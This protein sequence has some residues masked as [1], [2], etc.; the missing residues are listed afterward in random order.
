MRL[1]CDLLSNQGLLGLLLVLF[2]HYVL[3]LPAPLAA[4]PLRNNVD[5]L[6]TLNL[7]ST[8]EPRVLAKRYYKEYLTGAQ[9]V[10]EKGGIKPPPISDYPNDI[11]I[12]DAFRSEVRTRPFVFYCMVDVTPDN[13]GRSILS[14]TVARNF[15]LSFASPT[16]PDGGVF[17]RDCYPD[18]FTVQ[19][20]K[21]EI[22]RTDTWRQDFADR[23][24]GVMADNASGEVYFLFKRLDWTPDDPDTIGKV[25]TR[26]EY[27]TLTQNSAVTKITLVHW[28][29]RNNVE[30]G[31]KTIWPLGDNAA[32]A[33]LIKETVVMLT[34]RASVY[35]NGG[36][37]WE[38]YSEDPGDPYSSGYHPCCG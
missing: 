3:L 29:T 14:S 11:E 30:L 26:I 1:H 19:K 28:D 27:P 8:L 24:S 20:K 23:F 35:P 31:R 13:G 21:G 12:S 34:R 25:W 17:V 33:L 15:A 7:T 6:D 32:R 2:L 37:N 5:L 22:R 9:D 36:Y 10:P 4:S 16:L 18:R 38:G